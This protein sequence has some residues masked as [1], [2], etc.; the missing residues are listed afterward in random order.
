MAMFIM[1]CIA[2]G[3]LNTFYAFQQKTGL[4]PGSIRPVVNG[5]EKTGLLERSEGEKRGRRTMV[6]TKAGVTFVA[7]EWKK[8][9]DA[10][11]EVESI[12]R[13]TTVALLMHDIGAALN[14]LHQSAVE[15][16]RPQGPN[17]FGEPSRERGPIEFHTTTRAVYASRRRSME[18]VVLREIAQY[19]ERSAN[20]PQ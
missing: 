20:G 6:L 13:S 14:F 15:R 4:Q 5:L 2:H 11:R 7:E 9:L 17:E 18:A 19:L 10:K 8:G 12:L 16:E 1:A 3:G